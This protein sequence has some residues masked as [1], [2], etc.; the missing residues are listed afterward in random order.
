MKKVLKMFHR[1][2]KVEN[3]NQI[4]LLYIFITKIVKTL[5]KH[6]LSKAKEASMSIIM[7]ILSI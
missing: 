4:E 5:I 7:T 3:K 6:H 1:L 2:K